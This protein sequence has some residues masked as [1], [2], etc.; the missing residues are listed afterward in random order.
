M[1]IDLTQHPFYDTTEEERKKGYVRLVGQ[2]GYYIQGR[3]LSV[4]QG[5]VQGQLRDIAY[6]LYKDGD[7]IEGCQIIVDLET[8]KA[9]VT[10]GKV[11]YQGF[12]LEVN[13][14]S[15]DISA[16][17]KEVI[18][19]NVYEEIIDSNIDP[20]LR[21]QYPGSAAYG[22]SGHP[23]LKMT[24]EV[25]ARP[26]DA[27]NQPLILLYELE[28]GNPTTVR[29]A[30]QMSELYNVLARRTYDESGNYAVE[31]L[32][33][34]NTNNHD[35]TH[36]EV[37]LEPGKAYIE[38]YN[39]NKPA[40]SYYNIDKAL[41]T[42]SV[43]DE[44]FVFQSGI[45]TY[46]LYN[47][48][49]KEINLV[50]GVVEI[51]ATVTRGSEVGG[52]DD[53]RYRHPRTPIDQFYSSVVEIISISG[54]TKDVD[55]R[56]DGNYVDWSLS[57]S[58]PAPGTT[59]T[60]TWR[61]KK[62]MVPEEFYPGQ[63][64]YQLYF[65]EEKNGYIQFTGTG[66]LP[67]EG[68]LVEV[69]YK[70]YL[71]RHDLIYM[72]RYGN[73]KIIK[74]Q[75]NI[76]NLAKPPTMND[77]RVLVLGYII[78]SPNKDT[79]Y[80]IDATTKRITMERLNRVLNYLDTLAYNQAASDLDK[81][82]MEGEQATALKGILTDGFIGYTKMDLQHP[83]FSASID[84]DTQS[85]TNLQL[86]EEN[87]P[88]INS[89]ST[90]A[91]IHD[92]LITL[93][94]SEI[95]LIN[96]NKATTTMLI[97]PYSV[98][99]VGARLTLTPSIDKWTEFSQV[100]S[101]TETVNLNLGI[102][103]RWWSP[104]MSKPDYRDAALKDK[105]RL[106][107]LGVD[108][109][110][111]TAS[112]VRRSTHTYEIQNTLIVDSIIKEMVPYM[113]GKYVTLLGSNYI[114][115]T[116]NLVLKFAGFVVPTIPFN[117]SYR[118]T[119]ADTLKSDSKGI[120]KGSF[121]VPNNVIPC[122]T[123]DVTLSNNNNYGKT[124]YTAQGFK[125]IEYYKM[126]KGYVTVTWTDPLAQSFGFDKTKFVTGVGIYFATKGNDNVIVQVRDMVNGLPGTIVYA[127]KVLSPDQINIS[128]N[129]SVETKI[130][131]D[132]PIIC[133]SNTEYC[134]TV[135]SNSNQYSV[136]IAE[137][138]KTDIQTRQVVTEQ[139]YSIGI[140]FSSSNAT[141][142]SMHQTMDL[143]FK[144]YGAEFISNEAIVEFDPVIATLQTEYS[145]EVS[146]YEGYN[147][148]ALLADEI[149]LDNTSV[150][151]EYGTTGDDINY[152]W[153]PITPYEDIELDTIEKKIKLRATLLGSNEAS[154]ILNK[155]LI[156]FVGLLTTEKAEYVTKNVVMQEPFK[157]V[158]QII[159]VK[160]PDGCSFHV[161]LATDTFGDTWEYDGTSRTPIST[162]VL[163]NGYYRYTYTHTFNT[164][165]T[166]FRGKITLVTAHPTQRVIAKRFFNIMTDLGA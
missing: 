110:A 44:P 34:I 117:D 100:F 75:P 89:G 58:E 142:W 116:D 72:D 9:T 122:G 65:D 129:G 10:K 150:V 107:N 146:P 92:T 114:P 43:D 126:I 135:S 165:Q 6:T 109:E 81:E 113:R 157:E 98:F 18:G 37:M 158:K 91:E 86:R 22:Q 35:D 64:D 133:D 21:G 13:D 87:Q 156:S 60:C 130:V 33:I 139:P 118:G 8:K 162:E 74:G 36:I 148:I 59:Y 88:L 67:V 102:L 45:N 28:N 136:F 70:F 119:T 120:V 83:L 53:L 78:V 42:Q 50:E 111:I 26:A 23:R 63:A 137:L 121:W 71:T 166:E 80:Y 123:V 82:A 5:M 55:Y 85:I 155:E 17:G 11:F 128:S 153:K 7:I 151:W 31:G 144:L 101:G 159:D 62:K 56:Q 95:T 61:Y 49:V 112:Q 76:P 145:S 90:T 16:L 134:I 29:P 79:I 32:K 24:T 20:S 4:L 93:P 143:K 25:I 97:N 105:E 131:F 47:Q 40:A 68:T 38:G 84:F 104:H 1:P 149:V 96:Q 124:Q 30:P 27:P 39:V 69:T 115:L 15:V 73:V 140:L 48:P 12:L 160:V 138:G 127:E 94:Y 3:D 66:D 99:N 106:A 163:G 57:G 141:S 2:G 46:K 152:T 14:T 77:P 52:K 125:T 19:I 51:T 161:D 132:N 164:E 154:P 103:R 108:V 41:D 147:R 54:Y